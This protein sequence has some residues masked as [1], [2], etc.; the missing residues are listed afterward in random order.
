MDSSSPSDDPAR[1][2]TGGPMAADLTKTEQTIVGLV[3]RG[4]RNAEIATQLG[5]SHRT[6]EWHLSKVY[7]KLGVRSR[8]HVAVRI[9]AP[10]P[11]RTRPQDAPHALR[12]GSAAAPAEATARR[13]TR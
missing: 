7:R 1:E 10:V 6:V 9:L 4:A 5:L 3:V 13:E 12:G 2:T 8:T 11:E